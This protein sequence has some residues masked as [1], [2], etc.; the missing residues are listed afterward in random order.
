MDHHLLQQLQQQLLLL[1]AQQQ[2]NHHPFNPNP[3]PPYYP[4][5]YQYPQNGYSQSNYTNLYP[6]QAYPQ[7]AVLQPPQLTVPPSP[8]SGTVRP[9]W[10]SPMVDQPPY[11]GIREVG[12]ELFRGHQG[13]FGY[14]G[15]HPSFIGESY[16]PGRGGLRTEQGVPSTSSHP[17]HQTYQPPLTLTPQTSES[18]SALKTEVPNY[19]KPQVAQKTMVSWCEVCKASCT[20]LDVLKQHQSGRRH[21]RNLKNME[22]L[23]D[24]VRPGAIQRCTSNT[25]VEVPHQSQCEQG[26][27]EKNTT[28]NMLSEPVGYK[29]SRETGKQQAEIPPGDG[30]DNVKRGKKRKKTRMA[31][32]EPSKRKDVIPIACDLCNVK[33]ETQAVCEG[34]LS[35]KKHFAKY[36]RLNGHEPLHRPVGLQVVYPPNA[37]TE[38]VLQPQEG[39]YIP[40]HVYQD[41]L[42]ETS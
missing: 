13:N 5:Q 28:K 7:P 39:R 41:I 35:G 33:C 16:G 1:Q 15:A 21:Q 9:Q 34:H 37:V 27:E 12:G 36:K 17:P 25:K 40:P 6:L 3:H 19:Q 11:R 8:Y 18:A 4:P 32:V 23:K 14:R 29:A 20:N 24:G 30:S 26:G 38:T 22:R 10:A 2:P 42:V 31:G